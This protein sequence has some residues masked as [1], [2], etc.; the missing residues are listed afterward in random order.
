[1]GDV[2]EDMGEDMGEGERGGA[3]EQ[4]ERPPE[5]G[6]HRP[7]D[8]SMC[9]CGGRSPMIEARGEWTTHIHTH[10]RM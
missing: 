2:E 1:M 9:V 4:G 3:R 7:W 6:K 10:L 8:V 5:E